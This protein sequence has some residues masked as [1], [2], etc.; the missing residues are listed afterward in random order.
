MSESLSPARSRLSDLIRQR[1]AANEALQVL[2][3]RSQRLA[4]LSAAVQPHEAELQRHDAEEARI[5]SGWAA[6][7]DDTLPPVADHAARAEIVAR[8]EKARSQVRAAEAASAAIATESAP[9]HRTIGGVWPWIAQ[10]SALVIVEE[11]EALLPELVEASQALDAVRRRINGGRERVIAAGLR[12]PDEVSR[13]IR[14]ALEAFD[15]ARQAAE[16]AS[17]A[18]IVFAAPNGE[19]NALTHALTSDPTA[20]LASVNG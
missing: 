4:R 19:W 13:P 3:Q 11:L 2:A 7:A 15:K 12:G 1:T 9:H 6:D 20:S 5:M 18:G 16:T 10:A 17:Q 14:V 8:L